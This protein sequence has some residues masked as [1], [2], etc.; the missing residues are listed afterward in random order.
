LEIMK[1][2]FTAAQ[3]PGRCDRHRPFLLLRLAPAAGCKS[4][5]GARSFKSVTG[6]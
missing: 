1:T 3:P 5:G 6:T 2:C 4:A